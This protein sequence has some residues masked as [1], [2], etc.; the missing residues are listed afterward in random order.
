[1][2]I[3]HV[4]AVLLPQYEILRVIGRLAFPIFCFLL[5]EGFCHTSNWKKYLSRLFLFAILSEVPFDLAF[6]QTIYYP[7]IQNIFITLTLGLLLLKSIS[8]V[9]GDALNAIKLGTVWKEYGLLIFFAIAA[10]LINADYGALG[11]CMIYF[12]Y[13]FRNN[14]VAQAISL[15]VL[16]AAMG[17]VQCYACLAM[18]PIFFYSKKIGN[19]KKL[20]YLFYAYY[21]FHLLIL[22]VISQIL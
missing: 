16:S 15:G 2:T 10:D 17:G 19:C 12:F 13:V 1:M 6:Y 3:D 8:L 5:I 18:I 9:T 21:P 11:I 4:G 22:Y 14:I 7:D 20:K